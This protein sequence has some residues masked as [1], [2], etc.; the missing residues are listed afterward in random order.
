LDALTDATIK[1]RRSGDATRRLPFRFD[2]SWGE[3]AMRADILILT[4][5]HGCERPGPVG[6]IPVLVPTTAATGPGPVDRPASIFR[7]GCEM[8]VRLTRSWQ[9]RTSARLLRNPLVRLTWNMGH[10]EIARWRT[11]AQKMGDF[12]AVLKNN[13]LRAKQLPHH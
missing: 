8:V 11:I 5:D 7:C 3:V 9:T 1:N 6:D 13:P 12:A 10:E 4:A 2:S